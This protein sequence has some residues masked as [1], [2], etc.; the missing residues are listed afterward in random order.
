MSAARRIS[1]LAGVGPSP[2]RRYPDLLVHR[3]IKAVLTGRRYVPELAGG[4]AATGR[5][6]GAACWRVSRNSAPAATR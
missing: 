3:A 1:S 4:S 2:I 6:T 5:M